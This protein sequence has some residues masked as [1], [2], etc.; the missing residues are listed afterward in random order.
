MH[1]EIH[2][3]SCWVNLDGGGSTNCI[4]KDVNGILN[5]DTAS[6]TSELCVILLHSLKQFFREPALTLIAGSGC[7]DA[8]A[9]DMAG[10]D[11]VDAFVNG[12]FLR[13][14]PPG[15]RGLGSLKPPFLV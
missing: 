5:P 10:T 13:E 2:I 14:M 12:F 7:R 1:F 8:A 15:K 9:V 3:T 11:F 6:K 4:G